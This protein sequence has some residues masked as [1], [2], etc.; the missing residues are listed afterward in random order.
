MRIFHA[1]KIIQ[2]KL[3]RNEEFTIV[4]EFDAFFFFFFFLKDSKNAGEKRE[5]IFDRSDAFSFFFAVHKPP[6]TITERGMGK[7]SQRGRQAIVSRFGH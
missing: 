7:V 3:K 6:P 5:N 1:K 2:K 4:H